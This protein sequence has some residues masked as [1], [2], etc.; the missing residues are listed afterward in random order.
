MAT[1]T[2]QA[3]VD[4][5]ATLS[6]AVDAGSTELIEGHLYVA[7]GMDR[8]RLETLTRVLLGMKWAT[9]SGAHVL[10]VTELGLEVGRRCSAVFADAKGGAR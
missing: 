1:K 4:L 5:A 7:L 10:E 6:A 2:E 9:R 3:K 8:E